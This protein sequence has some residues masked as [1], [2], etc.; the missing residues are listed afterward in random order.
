MEDLLKQIR[1]ALAFNLYYLA[2]FSSLAL[3][4]V[5]SAL[6]SLN[7]QTSKKQYAAWFDQYAKGKCSNLLDGTECYYFRC[8]FLHQGNT[9]HK[10]LGY[11]RI[12]FIEPNSVMLGHDNIMNDALNLDLN[13]FCT[14]MISAVEEWLNKINSDPVFL[15]NYAVFMKRYK[16][17]LSPYIVGIPVIS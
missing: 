7:G 2:L 10:D 12:L 9:E 1:F 17:G 6:S 11:S 15:K 13:I 14:G 5:C 3:P 4:D 8:S 16:D